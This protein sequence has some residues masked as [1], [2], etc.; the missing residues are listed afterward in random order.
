MYTL[1]GY[2]L[3]ALNVDIIKP[4]MIIMGLAAAVFVAGGS[5]EGN[6]GFGGLSFG[7]P[8]FSSSCTARVCFQA[9]CYALN[10][11][12]LLTEQTIVMHHS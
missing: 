6:R 2:P 9:F 12:V 10:C 8:G 7:L 5:L 4:E 1:A 3:F 11:W